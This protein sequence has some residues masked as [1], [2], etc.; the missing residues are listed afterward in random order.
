MT[1][2]LSTLVVEAFGAALHSCPE[3]YTQLGVQGLAF[4]TTSSKSVRSKVETLVCREGLKILDSALATAQHSKQEQHTQAVAWLAVVLLRAE[5]AQPATATDVTERMLS[6]PSVPLSQ[7]KQLVAAGMHVTYAQLLAAAHSM[8]AGEEVWVQ[9]QQQL[10]VAADIPAPA[11]DICCG[12]D[13]VS[14]RM[15]AGH[16]HHAVS[17]ISGV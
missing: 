16:T 10:G 1:M 11:L 2:E 7:A 15:I 14:S 8:V 4:L 12:H 5:P 3:L 13:W 6:L 9:A 17:D